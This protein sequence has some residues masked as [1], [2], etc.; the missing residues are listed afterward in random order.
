[1]AIKRLLIV[2]LLAAFVM[3]CRP[4]PGELHTY[5]GETMGTYFSVQWRSGSTQQAQILREGM[6]RELLK[7]NQSM[8]TYIDDSEISR[9][10]RVPIGVEVDISS[11]FAD[12]ITLALE[13]SKLSRGTFDFTIAPLVNLWGFGPSETD[14]KRPEKEAIQALMDTV[15][16]QY[17]YLDESGPRL[18]KRR[19][20]M[21]DLSAIAKGYGVDQVAEALIELGQRDFLVEVGGEL[22]AAGQKTDGSAWK[23]AIEE[24]DVAARKVH[25]VV[26]LT[27]LAMATSGDYRNF[28]EKDQKR[29]SHT[30]DPRTARPIEHALA[31]VT[32]FHPEAMS[33]DALA[34][35]LN[36]LGP[37][38]G[39]ALAN[40]Q[41]LAAF[42]IVRGDDGAL[43]SLATPAFDSLRVAPQP[44]SE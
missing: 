20:A 8:S 35:A 32:V 30:I 15:G 25:T 37:E 26:R 19:A 40:A 44:I 21:I 3:G 18:S 22:R 12:V 43:H 29:Y 28:F 16:Y 17:I 23:I 38:A 1:M 41:N 9:F 13:I 4:S 42:F 31:S 36:V 5:Q 39:L 14:G 7:L 6:D 33:A 27:D 34:T 2:L 10:N 24:P 11:Y